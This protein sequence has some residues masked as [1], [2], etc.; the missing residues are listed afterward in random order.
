MN[1]ARNAAFIAYNHRIA[2]YIYQNPDWPNFTF[3]L[4]RL[5]EL[6]S[7]V[8]YRQGMLIGRMETLG[9]GAQQEATLES[10]VDEVRK[11]SE[12][13]GVT[14]DEV[15]VRSSVARR[16]GLDVG[17]LPEVDRSVEGVVSMVLDATQHYQEL[18]TKERILGW[19]SALFPT[20]WSEMERITIGAWRDDRKG[21]MQVVS[22]PVGKRTVHF[23]APEA[24]RVEVEMQMFLQHFE[25]KDEINPIL[26]AGIAHLWFVT[27]HPLDDGNGRI[28]RAIADLALA[29]ADGRNWRC[30][31]MSAQIRRE[32]NAYY[33]VLERTQKGGLDISGYL[34]WFLACLDRAMEAAEAT[35]S[36]SL[37]RARF[38]QIHAETTFNARQ[39]KVLGLLLSQT[40]DSDLTNAKWAKI[41]KTSSDTALRDLNDLIEKGV[42]RREGDIGRGAKYFLID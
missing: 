6:L 32:R 14:L 26:R 4:D 2:P 37:A 17:G 13:E 1:T 21:R 42:L 23:E 30:Y 40:V 8:R 3:Q 31:S 38:W 28:A 18:L 7:S 34:E 5:T 16:L 24:N 41:T 20:G 19:H 36:T 29:R 12:I 22:G 39:K 25:G 35:L 11:S 9:F 33:N 15:H 10:L 27:I